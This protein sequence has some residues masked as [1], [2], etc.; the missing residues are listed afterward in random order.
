M[1]KIKDATYWAQQIHKG[2]TT[3]AELLTLAEK[4]IEAVNPTYNAVVAYDLKHAQADLP[5]TKKGYFAGLPHSKCWDKI[6]QASLQL[7]A[8]NS[9]K[10]T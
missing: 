8:L 2:D 7:L 6:M 10:T 1:V 9:L 5:K 3:S 4:K